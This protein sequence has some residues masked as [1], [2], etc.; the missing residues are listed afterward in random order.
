VHLAYACR[1]VIA[2]TSQL[3]AFVALLVAVV[4]GMDAALVAL[5]HQSLRR[6]AVAPPAPHTR[7][8]TSVEPLNATQIIDSDVAWRAAEQCP[9]G[10]TDHV[11]HGGHESEW[12]CR[13]G[14]VTFDGISVYGP[15]RWSADGFD[16]QCGNTI[17]VPTE[18]AYLRFWYRALPGTGVF[19]YLCSNERSNTGRAAASERAA[20]DMRSA[21]IT[22]YRRVVVRSV[23]ITEPATDAEVAAWRRAVRTRTIARAAAR[24]LAGLCLLISILALGM[25]MRPSLGDLRRP[26][27]RAVASEGAATLDDGTCV[28]VVGMRDGPCLVEIESDRLHAPYRTGESVCALPYGTLDQLAAVVRHAMLRRFT[29]CVFAA[30]ASTVAV[31]AMA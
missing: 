1:N 7:F 19:E 12:R 4:A 5:A 31:L 3:R 14:P 29:V 28:R 20:S 23:P 6:P 9:D 10:D 21:S 18:I 2:K 17:G 13:V 8:D 22:A 25:P 26:W 11:W 27:Q 24:A 30:F 16:F 15:S